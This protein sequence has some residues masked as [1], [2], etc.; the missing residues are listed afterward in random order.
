MQSLEK[1]FGKALGRAG[2]TLGM[3]L[4]LG[5]RPTLPWALL[6][7]LIWE[8]LPVLAKSSTPILCYAS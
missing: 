2:M 4:E 6:A 7:I 1:H 3:I 5:N 8:N